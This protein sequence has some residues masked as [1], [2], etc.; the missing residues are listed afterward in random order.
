[1]L[2]KERRGAS[3][4]VKYPLAMKLIATISI[5]VVVS[6]GVTTVLSSWFFSDDSR[7]RAEEN[8]LTLS[9]VVSS[10]I[11]SRIDSVHASALSLFDVLRHLP[12]NRTVEQS[13][14]DD[15]FDRNPTIA[16]VAVPGKREVLNEKFFKANELERGTVAVA[17]ERSAAAFEKAR[18]GETTVTNA[19]PALGIAAAALIFPYRDLGADDIMMVL[20]STEGIQTI[21]QSGSASLTYAVD[22]DGMLLAHPDFDLLKLGADFSTDPLVT[23]LLKSPTD[24]RQVRY[25]DKAGDSYLGAIRRLSVGGVGVVTTV[26]LDTVYRAAQDIMR[27]NLYITGIVLTFSILAVWFLARAVTRPVKLLTS[28]LRKIEEGE[29]ILDL[30][31]TTRDEL[32]LFT[33][34]FVHMGRGLAERERMKDTFG[35]FVNKEIAELALKGE[36]ALGGTRKTATIFFSD[37]RSFTAISENMEPEAVVEFLNDYMTRMVDCIERT[38]GVVDKFIG[39]AIM[40][41]WGAPVSQGDPAGDAL[42]AITAA[43]MMRKALGEFNSGRGGP[44]KPILRIGCGVNTG[45]CLAGQIG[46]LKRMEYTVI[47]DAVNLASR[48][49]ALNKPFHTDILISENTCGLLK[50][51]LIVEPMRPIKAKGKADPLQ[52]FAVVNLSG[53]EGP[54]NLAEVRELLGIEPPEGEVDIDTEETKYEILQK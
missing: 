2:K 1:M 20:F 43:L 8:N 34:G 5:I 31:A 33:K 48:I 28:A 12:G 27:Q 17:Q 40:G 4:R 38:H 35:K 24:N 49:E 25:K 41:V 10:Q 52:I 3:T 26:P 32:G 19:T 22:G 46:S 18:S 42:N 11:E 29:F 13:I 54:R 45:P 47:G 16:C 36:L 21:I 7:A 37:I 51:R 23:E 9:E 53:A 15:F 39:D 6:M 50:D 30:K 14:V 44:G